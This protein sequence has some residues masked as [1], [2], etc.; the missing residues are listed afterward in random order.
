MIKKRDW[1]FVA[2]VV[3][4]AI[5]AFIYFD[6]VQIF[7]WVR[8]QSRESIPAAIEY[9][10]TQ[11]ASAETIVP[12]NKTTIPKTTV[13]TKATTSSVTIAAELN[14]AVPFTSQAPTGNWQ[15]PFQDACEEA[16][17]LMVHEF[18]SGN[19]KSVIDSVTAEKALLDLVALE[20]K[21][22]GF[23][24]D[25]NVLETAQLAEAKY[26]YAK[27]EIL[28][29]P[30][31]DQ[32]KDRLNQGDPVLVP[33]AGQL[34][35][36]PYFTSPGPIYHMMVI[37]GYTK[38]KQFIVNDPGTKH[39]AAYLYSFDTV[40]NAMHDWNKSGDITQGRKAVLILHPK[41]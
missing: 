34:L 21:L 24:L 37:R 35:K 10:E 38:N 41:L 9:Q 32:I 26:G 20:N 36:N 28:E 4:L 6:R 27:S 5:G 19:K 33:V 15:Q 16:S 3:C 14:L 25:T 17:I 2:I 29:N 18:Y 39:G 31:I 8:E 11:T 12:K 30:T 22:L 40:M 23:F 7:E 13:P 1:I